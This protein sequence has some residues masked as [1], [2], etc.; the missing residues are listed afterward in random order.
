MLR[1]CAGIVHRSFRR[2]EYFADWLTGTAGPIFVA[3]CWLLVGMGAWSYCR[4]FFPL[5]YE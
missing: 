5:G 3:I 1:F 2:F 4:S